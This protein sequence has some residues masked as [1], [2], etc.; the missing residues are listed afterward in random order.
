VSGGVY[1]LH[2]IK[3]VPGMRLIKPKWN[4]RLVRNLIPATPKLHKGASQ[5]NGQDD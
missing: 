1:F 5:K 2:A 4:E 3:R